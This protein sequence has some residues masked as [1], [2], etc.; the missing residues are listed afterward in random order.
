MTTPS[1]R[2]TEGMLLTDQYQLAMAQVYF[3]H[4]LHEDP[5]LFEYFFRAYPNYD[6]HQAGYCVNA[7]LGSLLEWMQSVRF[8]P[9]DLRQLR[10]QVSAGGEPLFAPDF[11]DWLEQAGTFE[12]LSLRAVPEGRIVHPEL[13]LAQV[14]GPL[15]M[16]QLLETAL[17]NQLNYQT[18]IATKAARI[19]D[20]AR[21]ATVL[22]FG[23][24]RAQGKG[25][26]SGTRAALIGGADFSSNVGASHL[27]GYPPKGTHAH[28][29]V[30]VFL[31]M[32]AGELDA[33]RAFAEIY[34]D[35][36]I[37]LVDTIDTLESG[38]PN[39]I[40]VFEE[41]RAGG[42]RP[43]GVRLDSGDLAYLSIQAARLLDQAGFPETKIVLSNDLDE[44]VI[45][46]IITQ[47]R[48]EAP[49]YEVDPGLLI[50]RLV[51]GVGTRLITSWGEPALGGVYKLVAF[52][53]EGEWRPVLKLSENPEKVPVPGRKLV[54][55]IYDQRGM[56]TADLICR[57]EE[58]N[59]A[60]QDP[61]RAYHPRDPAKRRE[62]W[63]DQISDI[64]P[65]L[66][67]VPAE[68]RSAILGRTIEQMRELRARDLERLDPGVRRLV[69]PHVYHVSLSEQLSD[70]K[71]RLVDAERRG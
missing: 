59:P 28:S 39:A 3:R 18:L 40:R 45:W 58:G 55:R 7:G 20:S 31:S 63:R 21:G 1:H 14:Q 30:Q 10:G 47:I 24:R 41:L 65:L 48:Q 38:I 50:E 49:R 9:H 22:E 2:L 19:K 46:Q 54:W 66:E 26:I 37:L 44:M 32:G 51:Y 17:L 35:D 52:H 33:F 12:A 34:P 67:D 4:G 56:S 36:C 11:L 13:P 69:N 25:G 43:V 8:E 6:G 23:L 70:L 5:A 57:E 64:E 29:M 62:L 15:A 42:H 71:W 16:A 61:I 60:R 27:F 68:G 53:S